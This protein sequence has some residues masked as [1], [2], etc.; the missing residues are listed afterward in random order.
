MP[1]LGIMVFQ[2]DFSQAY[3]LVLFVVVVVFNV[4]LHFGNR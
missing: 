3:C 1:L 4:F 2:R